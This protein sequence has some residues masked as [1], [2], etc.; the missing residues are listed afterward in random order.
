MFWQS[1]WAEII[2]KMCIEIIHN[3]KYQCN[4]T[5][6]EPSVIRPYEDC[7]G[8]GTVKSTARTGLS[9]I[10]TPCDDCKDSGAW[11]FHD[12]R[13]KPKEMVEI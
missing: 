5:V 2:V 3:R 11:V 13:W 1:Y 9:T 6:D 12:G 10:R 7:G 8:C 4:H